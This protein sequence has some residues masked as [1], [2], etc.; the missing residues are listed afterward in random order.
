MQHNKDSSTNKWANIYKEN[1]RN[2]PKSLLYM[3]LKNY[4]YDYATDFEC[5]SSSLFSKDK[6]RYKFK[7]VMLELK[8][9]LITH[10][11]FLN[12]YVFWIVCVN[13]SIT[14]SDLFHPWMN[15]CFWMNRFKWLTH[16][17][18]GEAVSLIRLLKNS[19]VIILLLK[20]NVAFSNK[21]ILFIKFI[22][23]SATKTSFCAPECF[24]CEIS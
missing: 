16:K 15:H 5:V 6:L 20:T 4:S 17:D 12:N 21:V 14:H 19:N 18:N 3:K 2:V 1:L 22:L 11:S 24:V 23:N 13:G 9:F 8:L 7:Q 10:I